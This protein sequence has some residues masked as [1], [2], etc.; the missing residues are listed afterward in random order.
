VLAKLVAGIDY[1]VDIGLVLF[2]LPGLSLLVFGYPWIV[3]WWSILLL[4]IT[5]VFGF[6]RRWQERHVFR[7]LTAR[8]G[9]SSLRSHWLPVSSRGAGSA[10]RRG[11]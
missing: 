8:A 1:L 6:L 3:G 2:W 10:S 7:R 4:P 11:E 9:L 5:L